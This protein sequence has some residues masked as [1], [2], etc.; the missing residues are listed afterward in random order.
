[1]EPLISK[2]GRCELFVS[3]SGTKELRGGDP[4]DACG[5]RLPCP[6]DLSVGEG[7]GGPALVSLLSA[8][9]GASGYSWWARSQLSPAGLCFETLTWNVERGLS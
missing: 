3:Q 5:R 4:L 6:R 8:A 2:Q 7:T 9:P 1:M